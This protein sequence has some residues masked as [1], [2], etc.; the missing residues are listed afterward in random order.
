[1]TPIVKNTPRT[2]IRLRLI[3]SVAAI[4]ASSWALLIQPAIA[5]PRL[6]EV[7]T[8]LLVAI[9]V[10]NSV[11][12]ARYRLQMEGIAKA[13]EDPG[14]VAAIT[15]GPQG[16]IAFAIL[17]WADRSE[18]TFPWVRIASAAQAREVAA[19]IRTLPRVKGE[20]TCLARMLR[21]VADKIVPQI[22]AI[23]NRTVIDVSGDGHENCNPAEPSPAVRDELVSDKVVING[24]PILDG[25]EAKSIEDWYRTNVQGGIG[26]F[27]LAANGYNDFE[28]AIRQK[29]VVEISGLPSAVQ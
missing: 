11:D 7:D 29:F 16:A 15:T 23:A 4:L 19:R 20:F 5:G 2:R 1:M 12:E 28:R 18:L 13:L 10:S 6:A 26:S 25:G 21:N 22:P 17:T 24:L 27:T 8:A 9:D 3:T 14:V